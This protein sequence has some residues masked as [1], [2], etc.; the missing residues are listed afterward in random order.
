MSGPEIESARRLPADL[1]AQLIAAGCFRMFVP[2]SHGGIEIDFPTSMGLIES[3]ATADGATG[4]VVMIGCETPMLLALMTPK[5]FDQLYAA[6]PDVIIAGAFAPRGEAEL[7]DRNYRVK[8]RWG[9]ASGCEHASWLFGN[10]VV[11]EKGRPR[12][13]LIPNAPEVRGMMVEASRAKIIAYFMF[14]VVSS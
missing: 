8:G 1:L 10:C 4:W 5:R 2:H 13:S 12:Q 7:G 9:F 11:T 6:S 14:G 3:V